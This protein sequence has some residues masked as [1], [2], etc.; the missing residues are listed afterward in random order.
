MNSKK[1]FEFLDK[2]E[3]SFREEERSLVKDPGAHGWQIRDANVK[4]WTAQFVKSHLKKMKN[5]DEKE[6]FD[7]LDELAGQFRQQEEPAGL[8]LEAG[9]AW[10]EKM[11]N[12][13]TISR[14]LQYIKK[15]IKVFFIKK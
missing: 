3:S 10:R 7:F 9:N 15:E 6:A 2:L 1:L 14:T 11:E 8:N 12:Y 13:Q 4:L 5:L